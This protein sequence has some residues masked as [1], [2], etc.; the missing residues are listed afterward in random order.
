MRV[1]CSK[2]SNSI[3]EQKPPEMAALAFAAKILA[4]AMASPE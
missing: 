4:T 1:L 2:T 3:N